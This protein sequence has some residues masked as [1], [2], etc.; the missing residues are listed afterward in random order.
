MTVSKRL[1]VNDN[2]AVATSAGEANGCRFIVSCY[3]TKEKE[4]VSPNAPKSFRLLNERLSQSNCP[5]IQGA[6]VLPLS[7][8]KL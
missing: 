3:S 1:R 6:D 7:T 2:I 5:T 8:A 4:N